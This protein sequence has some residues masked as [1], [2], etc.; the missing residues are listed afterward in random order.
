MMTVNG[1]DNVVAFRREGCDAVTKAIRNVL[2]ENKEVAI[3]WR[4][5]NEK[6]V[7]QKSQKE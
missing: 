3:W 7:E 5:G 1:K 6:T 4:L 2:K